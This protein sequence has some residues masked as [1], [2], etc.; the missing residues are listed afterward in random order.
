M[1]S[2]SK[3]TSWVEAAGPNQRCSGLRGSFL[4]R[5]LI[6]M[7]AGLVFMALSGTSVTEGLLAMPRS[8]YH[9][10][11]ASPLSQIHT[12]NVEHLR[13]SRRVSLEGSAGK[14]VV[15]GSSLLFVM[16]HRPAAVYA[17]DLDW[18]VRVRWQ[19][20]L[21]LDPD[22]L[23]KQRSQRPYGLAYS[24]DTVFAYS[25]DTTL[26]ALDAQTGKVRW[27]VLVSGNGTDV[28]EPIALGA[29]IV[30]EDKVMVRLE[31]GP[32]MRSRI[33][34]YDAFT[35]RSEWTAYSTGPDADTLLDPSH[36]THLLEPV[37]RD[38]LSRISSHDHVERLGPLVYDPEQ[39]LIYYSS[40]GRPTYD[41]GLAVPGFAPTT[42]FARSPR[43][44]M[45]T[46][47]YRFSSI[48]A[49]GGASSNHPI[50]TAA[51]FEQAPN[52]TGV[53]YFDESGRAFG[54][55]TAQGTALYEGHFDRDLFDALEQFS[56]LTGS[57]E[58]GGQLARCAGSNVPNKS[59]AFLPDN[60]TFFSAYSGVCILDGLSL[61]RLGSGE[62]A[63][64]NPRK[65]ATMVTAW[66]P[67]SGLT[68]RVS[69]G[70]GVASNLLAT[71][72]RLLIYGTSKGELVARNSIDGGELLRLKLGDEPVTS[73]LTFVEGGE[74]RIVV[75]VG[76]GHDL[77]AVPDGCKFC[78]SLTCP[79][80]ADACCKDTYGRSEII[81]LRLR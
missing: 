5:H 14:P 37:G 56:D 18:D 19:Y 36:T 61:Y 41:G 69:E 67:W 59:V 8:N 13:A 75:V 39:N 44:G 49:L 68:W 45:A 29:P 33:V 52:A 65:T 70:A 3:A 17:F 53:F 54:L 74:Q 9:G 21:L 28:T 23:R 79:P 51:Q 48:D 4:R 81:P 40:V 66:R 43:D 26:T 2:R 72:G 76:D 24:A 35:G 62:Y 31:G 73:V 77:L 80:C 16:T 12:G 55:D 20:N 63:T 50:V 27:H 42:I 25:P 15:V 38:S 6:R 30:V 11:N 1:A 57:Y 78:K 47:I 32:G 22:S 34:A 71:S 46:W 10:D 7:A 60:G 64:G 58:S